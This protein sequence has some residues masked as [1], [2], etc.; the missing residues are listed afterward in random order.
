MKNFDGFPWY[1]ALLLLAFGPVGAAQSDDAR[2]GSGKTAEIFPVLNPA[3]TELYFSRPGFRNNQGRDNASDIWM[4]TRDES[5]RWNR[6]INV[7]S[8]LNS[9]SADRALGFSASG[10]RIAVLRGTANFELEI[11]QRDGRSW[12]SLARTRVPG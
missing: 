8:P 2:I 7:G 6:A 4:R 10:N 3:A 11:L 5:G 1:L 9:S 12:K